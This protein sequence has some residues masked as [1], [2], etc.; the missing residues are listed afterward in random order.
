MATQM[1]SETYVDQ[2]ESD[3]SI[4]ITKYQGMMGSLLYLTVSRPKITFS[5]SLCACFQANPKESHITTVKRITKYLKRTRLWYP[6]YSI[7][8]LVG[9][10]DSD[11]TGCKSDRKSISGTFHILRKELISWPCKKKT[12][13]ALSIGE[14]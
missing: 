9:Y 13:V 7:C 10:S 12:C 4:D 3:V 8:D 11:Y 14:A 2:D 6:K 5:V 1:G